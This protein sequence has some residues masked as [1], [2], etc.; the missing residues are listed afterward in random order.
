[1]HLFWYNSHIQIHRN[2]VKLLSLIVPNNYTWTQYDHFMKIH[3][4]GSSCIE[5][6]NKKHYFSLWIFIIHIQCFQY[7][8]SITVLNHFFQFSSE[9]NYLLHKV[10]YSVIQFVFNLLY[11]YTYRINCIN[12]GVDLLNFVNQ[13]K[14]SMWCNINYRP[15]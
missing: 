10:N 4:Q 5:I 12:S 9:Y 14:C 13:K 6:Y 11:I 8:F 15:I 2:K 3:S 1:M 7:N